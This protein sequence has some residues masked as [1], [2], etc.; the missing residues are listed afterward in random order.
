VQELNKK[1][2]NTE[3]KTYIQLYIETESE[4]I[5]KKVAQQI[6]KLDLKTIYLQKN[7]KQIEGKIKFITIILLII[8]IIIITT[9]ILAIISTYLG[10][11]TERYKEIG[12]LRALGATKKQIKNQII[13][14]AV[15]TGSI[16]A[17]I[18]TV[19]GTAT[20]KL[21]DIIAIP[22]LQTLA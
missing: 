4:D 16:G 8:T 15:I 12:L 2:Q 5:T 10:T 6:E 17:I 9:S 3:A 22:E 20:S 21:I 7:L 13:T 18:G 11:I 14:Q 1:Y 19:L